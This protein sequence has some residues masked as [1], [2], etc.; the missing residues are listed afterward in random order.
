VLFAALGLGFLFAEMGFINAFTILFSSPTVTLSVALGG[1]L[2]FAGIGGLASSRLPRQALA[3]L[4]LGAALI[5]LLT[6]AALP[7]LVHALLPLSLAAR[8]AG[9]VALL[10]APSVLLGMPFP[11]AMRVCPEGGAPP[12]DGRTADQAADRLGGAQA[13]D[14][15]PAATWAADRQ[16]AAAW[17]ANGAASVVAASAS[18]LIALS[19]GTRALLLAAAAGYLLALAAALPVRRRRRSPRS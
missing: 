2:A 15:Q 7:A 5:C 14:R 6:A 18:M 4:A 3:P 17:A 13:A 8:I 16:R 10:A 12:G 9:C 1:L 11:L 19:L